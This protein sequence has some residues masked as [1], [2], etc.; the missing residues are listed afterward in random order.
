MRL[1]IKEY[2]KLWESRCYPNGIPDEVPA[3]IKDLVPSYKRIALAILNNDHGLKSLGLTPKK[4]IYYH[5][6]KKIEIEARHK[7]VTK[8]D[9]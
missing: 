5:Q 6:L 7:D 8:T 4:S 3:E 9:I 1:K 2:I